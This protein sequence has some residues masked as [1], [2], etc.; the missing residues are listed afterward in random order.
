MNFTWVCVACYKRWKRKANERD[1]G[2]KCERQNTRGYTNFHI[3]FFFIQKVVL[4]AG[5]EQAYT[6][7]AVIA[8]RQCEL[9]VQMKE[10]LI[11]FSGVFWTKIG[12]ILKFVSCAEAQKHLCFIVRL[13]NGHCYPFNSNFPMWMK[14]SY[15]VDFTS[16]SL[17]CVESSECMARCSVCI[18]VFVLFMLIMVSISLALGGRV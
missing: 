2:I 8:G 18:C 3:H 1:R 7:N 16:E 15:K 11:L 13:D 14:P 4:V 12:K 6:W 10:T 5:C 17:Y 9:Y